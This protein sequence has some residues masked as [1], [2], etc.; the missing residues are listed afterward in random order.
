MTGRPERAQLASSQDNRR[1]NRKVA[2]CLELAAMSSLYI[3]D[4]DDRGSLIPP[5]FLLSL[6]PNKRTSKR[7]FASPTLKSV[8]L[9]RTYVPFHH[10]EARR[11][12]VC[13]D[14]YVTNGMSA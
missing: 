4:G 14:A 5:I 3:S 8:P 2:H 6:S 12:G 9:N 10:F 1:A 7:D 13:W 11:G